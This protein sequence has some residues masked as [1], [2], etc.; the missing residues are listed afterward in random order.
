MGSVQSGGTAISKIFATLNLALGTHT[1]ISKMTISEQAR[2]RIVFLHGQGSTVEQIAADIGTH[3]TTVLRWLG[4]YRSTGA[5]NERPHT[6]RRRC[7]TQEEDARI[8]A[9]V[10]ENP[11][12]SIAGLHRQH[13]PPHRYSTCVRR[14][15]EAGLE[16]RVMRQRE[17]ALT[18]CS[19]GRITPLF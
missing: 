6:G 13:N 18:S 10:Q 1:S 2:A 16:L 19:I 4:R 11:T 15:H 7:T 3:R 17:A 12:T 9:A 8:V 14:I 5:T